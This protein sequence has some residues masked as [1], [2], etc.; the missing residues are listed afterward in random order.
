M[1][2][3]PKT[4]KE[5]KEATLLA[6]GEYDFTVVRAEDKKS[7][8]GKDMIKV[9]L[10]IYQANGTQRLIDDYLLESFAHKLRHFAETIGLIAQY[11]MGQLGADELEGRAGKVKIV[12][13]DQ[14]DYGPKNEVKDYVVDKSKRDLKPAPTFVN[15][16][17]PGEEDDLPI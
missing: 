11:E 5:I 15:K 4:E 6:P 1:Q 3:T 8:S 17:L 13:K 7:K 10:G 12:I 14:P 9:T 16:P 2:F